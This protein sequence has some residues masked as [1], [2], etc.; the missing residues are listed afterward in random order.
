MIKAGLIGWI[1]FLPLGLV[2]MDGL[3]AAVTALGLAGALVAALIGSV[4]RQ[5]KAVL[6]YSSVSQMGLITT[7]FGIG[8]AR[9][10]AWDTLHWVAVVYAAHHAL[11]K[12]LLFL[13]VGIKNTR[14][15]AGIEAWI[16]WSVAGVAA[17]SLAG[18][19]ATSGM[20]AKLVLKD[21]VNAAATARVDS[22]LYL[23]TAA[24][25]GTTLLM[26]RFVDVLRQ[27]HHDERHASSKGIL[28][29]WL[30]LL[31]LSC[32]FAWHLAA[33]H[34]PASIEVWNKPEYWIKASWPIALG[35]ALYWAEKKAGRLLSD[36]WHVPP[37]D[38]YFP[39]R[40]IATG[41][42]RY[43]AAGKVHVAKGT[44][45]LLNAGMSRL[46]LAGKAV[47]EIANRAENGFAVWK[48]ESLLLLAVGALFFLLALG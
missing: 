19:P 26:A 6:A 38:L 37:G 9:P 18:A 29:P 7:V 48:F 15:V 25:V 21:A 24:A 46:R 34:F 23:L 39:I 8:L 12:G 31:S 11:A 20:A 28:A 43:A 14:P 10:E 47:S 40:G 42:S 32:I 30:L 4:Q 17:L 36:E 1:N 5:A 3:G 35:T 44:A 27:V 33:K 16:F 22:V 45:A 13:C 41:I 2:S